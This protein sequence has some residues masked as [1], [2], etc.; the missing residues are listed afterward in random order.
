MPLILT[1]SIL[2]AIIVLTVLAW[3]WNIKIKVA[4]IGSVIIG[5]ISGLIVY[6]IDSSVI[7]LNPFF[8][9]VVNFKASLRKNFF[10]VI[11]FTV[12]F[13]AVGPVFKPVGLKLGQQFL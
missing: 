8:Q 13:Q 3:K 10:A 7:V 11:Q 6:Y 1:I 12:M 9:I 4:L 5:A 2:E